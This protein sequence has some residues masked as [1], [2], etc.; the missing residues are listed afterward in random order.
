MLRRDS[1]PLPLT[2]RIAVISLMGAEHLS[3][4][5]DELPRS[6]MN[7]IRLFHEFLIITVR[8]KTNILTVSLRRVYQF[9][10]LC[11]LTHMI[12]AEFSQWEHGMCQLLLRQG[13]QY[14]ALILRRIQR[15][16]QLIAP[17]FLRNAGIMPGYDHITAQLLCRLIQML[18]FQMPVTL[19]TR[20]RRTAF[21]IAV[22]K[23]IHDLLFKIILIVYHIIRNPDRSRN[24]S[25]VIHRT[26][27][28]AATVLF[29]HNIFFVL[30]DLHGHTYDII[31]L[32]F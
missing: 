5:T 6:Y 27:S 31:S 8:Y 23:G 9:V 10:F 19:N 11:D 32:L 30:P 25:C 26:Q 3:V 20:I 4:G 15:P 28:T 12:L 17:V 18:E 7:I 21:Q 1:Q 2:D 14:I 24:S 16:S 13:I 29:L 22:Y